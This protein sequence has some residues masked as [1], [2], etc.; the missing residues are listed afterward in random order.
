M[1]RALLSLFVLLSACGTTW[2]VADLDGDGRP[3]VIAAGRASHNVVIYWNETP[4]S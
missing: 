3:E 4:K 1:P 2:T